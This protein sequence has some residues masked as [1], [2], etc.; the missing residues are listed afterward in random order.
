MAKHARASET[1]AVIDG[2]RRGYLGGISPA[3]CIRLLN[4]QPVDCVLQTWRMGADA[5]M[6]FPWKRQ[7][8]LSK[9]YSLACARSCAPGSWASLE[10]APTGRVR[11]DRPSRSGQTHADAFPRE[12][13]HTLRILHSAFPIVAHAVSAESA[14]ATD[15]CTSALTVSQLNA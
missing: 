11:R 8:E 12:K 4:A 6:T 2:G 3:V 15:L 1:P 10:P 5:T 9:Q 7:I 13:G 14:L